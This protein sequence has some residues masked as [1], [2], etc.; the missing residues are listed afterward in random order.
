MSII[1]L[2]VVIICLHFVSLF[3]LINKKNLEIK[4]NRVVARKYLNENH[5]LKA[6]LMRLKLKKNKERKLC[7]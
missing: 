5:F 7:R 6:E 1:A 4:I 2:I 3:I